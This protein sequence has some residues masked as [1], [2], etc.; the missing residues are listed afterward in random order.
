MAVTSSQVTDTITESLSGSANVDLENGVI[1]NVKL[2][3]FESKNGRIYPPKVVKAAVHVY[4]GAKVNINHP[5]GNDPTKP[6]QYQDRF[7]VIRN[8]RFVEGKGNFGDFHFNPKHPHAEQVAWDA[9]NN[10]EALGFSHNAL[11]RLGKK[12]GGKQVIEE[13][14]NIRSMDL[15]ADPATT[16]SLFESEQPVDPEVQPTE[17]ATSPQEQIKSAFKQMIMAAID[18]SS[19]DMKATMK[20]ISEIMKA[21]MKLMGGGDSAPSETEESVQLRQQV[22]LLQQQIEQFQAKEKQDALLASIDSALESAG[23]DKKNTDQVSELFVKQLIATESE[24]A[25]KAMIEDRASLV[26]ASKNSGG[27]GSPVYRPNGS[28]GNATEQI[29]LTS[30][31]SRLRSA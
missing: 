5:E 21:Q 4:E 20:K 7:G 15:V 23:L 8:V 2:I 19:L 12:Q 3:G 22:G 16:A 24:D 31:V 26:G 6:R 9:E 14:I 10:P 11:L 1:R 30:F 25:R 13:I 27:N 28:T 17:S 18:D 29:D